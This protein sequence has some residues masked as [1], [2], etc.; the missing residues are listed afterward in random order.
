MAS[1]ANRTASSR[2]SFYGSAHLVP[3]RIGQQEAYVI[4]PAGTVDASRRWIWFA[5]SWMAVEVNRGSPWPVAGRVLEHEFY[6]RG[7]LDA[8]FYVAGVNVGASCGSPPGAAV[9]HQL[10]EALVNE[11]GLSPHARLLAQSNGGL[12]HYAWAARHPDCVARI[13]GIFPATDLR[14]WPGLERASGPDRITA[15]GLGYDM[16]P[17]ELQER[18]GELN[19]I[20]LIGP[21]ASHG[22]K[23]LHIHGDRDTT[24]PLDANSGQFVRRYR[25]LGGEI[26]LVVAEGEGHSRSPVFYESPLAL[27]FL[28]E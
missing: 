23:I 14:S 8:G 17:Q 1:T 27:E 4:V 28:L 21:L 19:P 11:Y 10:Y 15:P 12:I 24:V 16:T 13:F 6:V 25:E 5:P 22:V 20:E 18:L 26:E 2:D 9:C 7:A 3:L